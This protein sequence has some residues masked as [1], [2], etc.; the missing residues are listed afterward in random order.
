MPFVEIFV[1]PGTARAAC[2]AIGAGVHDALVAAVD[3]P[4]ADRF[5]VINVQTDGA[6]VWDR[7]YLD[8]DRSANA[9]FVRITLAAGRSDAKKRALYAAITAN[10]ER[11]AG[12]RP[13]DVLILLCE[14]ARVDWSFGNGIAQYVP[15]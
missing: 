15:N 8:V 3:V 4:P 1:S 2:D 14:N 11:D 12:V 6:M 9:V 5:Q 7:T 10:L 13:E